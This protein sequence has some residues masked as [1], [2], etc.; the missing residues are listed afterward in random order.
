MDQR[1]HLKIS[2][3]LEEA[4]IQLLQSE[5]IASLGRLA[6]GVAH[7]INNPLAGIL[8]YA[9]MLMR[10][11]KHNPQWRQDL[12]EII[13]QTLRCKQIVIRLLEFSRQPLGHKISFEV[14]E[15]LDRSVALLSNL[16]QEIDFELDLQFDLPP[17]VGDS[18]QIQQVFTNI[19][20]NAAYAMD[21][22]GRL[23]ISSSFDQDGGKVVLTFTDTGPGIQPEIADKIFEPFFTTRRPGEGT[24]LGL[25]VAYGIVQQHGGEIQAGNAPGGGAEFIITLPLECPECTVEMIEE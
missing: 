8:I 25:S 4:E 7:E 24:G 13:D 19:I 16:F 18:G 21:G 5:K 14:N 10:D 17:V 22:K 6:A 20:T 23:V 1:E 15:L 2:K 3:Q 12:Q 9:E 11:V